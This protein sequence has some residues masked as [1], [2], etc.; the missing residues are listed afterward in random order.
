KAEDASRQ[1]AQGPRRQYLKKGEGV[2]QPTKPAQ[3][4][5]RTV[6]NPPLPSRTE[7]TQHTQKLSSTQAASRS[8]DYISRN[9]REVMVPKPKV[10]AP[11]RRTHQAGSIPKY[12]QTRKTEW[13]E[14]R[15]HS[16]Q[17]AEMARIQALTPPGTR[18]VG[19]QEK[20][21]IL[22]DLKQSLAG[23]VLELNSFPSV[24]DTLSRIKAREACEHRI[25]DLEKAIA[26]FEKPMVFIRDDI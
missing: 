16:A 22:K 8:K 6:R 18:L 10:A 17:A 2:V 14:Q 13:A 15:E 24:V 23:A 25:G 3:K 5:D 12:L 26:A 20:A 19:E 11:P 21:T 7:L 4:A 1:A 9:T